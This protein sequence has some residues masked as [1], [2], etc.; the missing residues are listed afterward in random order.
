MRTIGRRGRGGG[1][2]GSQGQAPQDGAGGEKQKGGGLP[3][4]PTGTQRSKR[5]LKVQDVPTGL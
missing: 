2:A 5:Y 4:G 1:R 3:K